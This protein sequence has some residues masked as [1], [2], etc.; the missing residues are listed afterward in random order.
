MK[1][2]APS[3]SGPTA[4]CR[5]PVV[6]HVSAHAWRDECS[7]L[8][9]F[10]SLAPARVFSFFLITAKQVLC[11]KFNVQNIIQLWI[12]KQR[13]TSTSMGPSWSGFW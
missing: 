4:P 3:C 12:V 11:I 6:L 13:H 10:L 2:A 5:S 1:N 8:L 7:G 9:R